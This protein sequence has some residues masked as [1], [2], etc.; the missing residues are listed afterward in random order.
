MADAA[1]IGALSPERL[2][3]PAD[4][5]RDLPAVAVDEE[6][7]A[8]VGHGK[9]LPVGTLGVAGDRPW[10]VLGPDGSL[11]AVYEQ[12]PGGAKPAVV[13]APTRSPA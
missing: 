12:H 7:A 6:V 8:A 1:P 9:I 13:I 10:R 3:T 2:L 11:L 4:A 5:L